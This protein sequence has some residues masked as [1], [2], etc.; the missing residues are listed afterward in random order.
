MKMTGVNYAYYKRFFSGTSYRLGLSAI[1]IRTSHFKKGSITICVGKKKVLPLQQFLKS[2][3]MMLPTANNNIFRFFGN[4]LYIPTFTD[5]NG[6]GEPF[7]S[8]ESLQG[9]FSV[10]GLLMLADG[11]GF[12]A[13]E[14]RNSL[15]TSLSLSLSLSLLHAI[16]CRGAV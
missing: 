12:R 16:A 1:E 5:G 2:K 10:E 15:I 13:R 6:G 11:G 8:S 3:L 14:T 4:A 7:F 9:V